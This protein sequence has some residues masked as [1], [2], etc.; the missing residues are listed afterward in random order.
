M[1][2]HSPKTTGNHRITADNVSE[3]ARLLATISDQLADLQQLAHKIDSVAGE[4]L[5]AARRLLERGRG[6]MAGRWSAQ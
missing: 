5:P 1:P 6:R 2:E 3:E 4:F